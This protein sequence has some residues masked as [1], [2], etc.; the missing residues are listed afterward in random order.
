MLNKLKSDKALQAFLEEHHQAFNN[1]KFIGDDPISIPH[2]YFNPLDIEITGLWTA[3]LS[4]GQRKTIINKSNELFQLMDHAPHD[5]ILNHQPKDRIR[6][7]HFK[8]RTFQP[9]DCFTFLEFFQ[10]TYQEHHSL[11]EIFYG[12]GN[13]KNGII[14]FRKTYENFTG[15]KHRSL[16]HVSTPEKKSACKRINMFLRWMVR[17]DDKGVDFGI[18][19]DIKPSQLFIPLDVHVG[20]VARQLGLLTRKNNDWLAVEEL[21]SN[22]KNYDDTDPVK[23]DFSLFGLGVLGNK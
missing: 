9:E 11:Q 6:F 5:F 22:L 3:I 8:H 18:W 13:I 20:R 12:N 7:K 14:N 21:T 15:S 17:K 23:Y 4:W 10:Q 19:S 16:K 2:Q 1:P